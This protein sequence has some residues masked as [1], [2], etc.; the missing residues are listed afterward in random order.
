MTSESNR[1]F[2]QRRK[3]FHEKQNEISGLD[4][5]YVFLKFKTL[6]FW[7]FKSIGSKLEK[8]EYQTIVEDVI[9]KRK[10]SLTFWQKTSKVRRSSPTTYFS[11]LVVTFQLILSGD[12]ETNPGK[13]RGN[14]TKQQ[15]ASEVQSLL[16]SAT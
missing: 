1:R 8:W 12:I 11:H 14:C 15:Q 4:L 3:F 7:C 2:F 6:F 9:R 10:K 16:K 5:H 13:F